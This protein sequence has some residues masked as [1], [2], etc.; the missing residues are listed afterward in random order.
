MRSPWKKIKDLQPDAEY[1]VLASAIPTK[2]LRSTWQMFRGA[3]AVREQ[4]AS[5]EGI[6]GFSL[7]ARPLRKQYATL[8]VW[9]HQAALDAFVDTSPHT[10]LMGALAADMG[11]THFERWT[12]GGSQRR[13][14]WSE[15]LKRL[16]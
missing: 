14:S 10:E 2:S 15:A 7:L 6:V 1:L 11:P 12:I 13:P 16:G 4:L 9:T 3:S 8:S 5:T